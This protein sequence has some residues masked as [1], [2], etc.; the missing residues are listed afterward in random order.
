MPV[1]RELDPHN[2]QRLLAALEALFAPQPTDAPA[3]PSAP[4]PPPSSARSLAKIVT[5]APSAKDPRE[6]RLLQRLLAAE[7]GHAIARATTA[8]EREGFRV[9]RDHECQL[10]MLEHPDEARVRSAIDEVSRLI[11]S[12]APKRRAVLD[13]RLRR[14]EEL[15]EERETR[16]AAASLRAALRGRAPFAPGGAQT[17]GPRGRD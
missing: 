14:I 7:G 17:Q 4:P 10:Q 8:L 16:D 1:E 13:A 2:R 6:E 9:P 15:A 3:R 11:A 12:S 5:A